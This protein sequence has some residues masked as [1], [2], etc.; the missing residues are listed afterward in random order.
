MITT[1]DSTT[2]IGFLIDDISTVV[3]TISTEEK[4]E[5][6]SQAQVLSPS[7]SPVLAPTQDDYQSSGYNPQHRPLFPVSSSNPFLNNRMMFMMM[8]EKMRAH[9]VSSNQ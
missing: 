2:E 1:M 9:R 4:T 6:A 5:F 7:L 3:P 8:L